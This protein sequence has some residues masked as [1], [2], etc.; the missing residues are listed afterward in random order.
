MS[1]P[2]VPVSRRCGSDS[3]TPMRTKVLCVAS[4][5]AAALTCSSWSSIA[6]AQSEQRVPQLQVDPFWPKPLPNNWLLGQVSG[7]AVDTRDHVWIVQ[8]PASLSERE[9][10]AAQNPPLGKCCV[11]AP[12]V[13]VFDQSGNLVRAWGGPGAGYEW[14]ASE[15]GIFVDDERLRL[16]RRQRRQRLADPQVHARR[17]VPAADRQERPVARQQRHGEP[18]QPGRPA[19]R[20]RGARGLRRRRLSQPPRH[21]VRFGDRRLQAA[22]GRVRRAAE[23]RA[24]RRRTIPRQPPS[25]QFGNPVHCVRPDARRPRLR[26]RPH[27][28]PRADLP[29]GRHVRLR[30]VLR[31]EHAA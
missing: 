6:R 17:Q 29:Q 1:S 8:R 16:A 31:E 7:V 3:V 26:L 14:P 24:R 21:R 28:Q 5:I 12:P 25:R 27:Q 10:G 2:L 20:R 11:A 13:L 30:G 9:L 22:L 19:R 15:H 23:R 4:C 18:R